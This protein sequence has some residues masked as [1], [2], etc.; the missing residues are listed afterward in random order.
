MEGIMVSMTSAV[1]HGSSMVKFNKQQNQLI[2]D[3]Q[4]KLINDI[5]DFIQ[6]QAQTTVKTSNA[7]KNLSSLS[8][9]K[10]VQTTNNRMYFG[11]FDC[12]KRKVINQKRSFYPINIQ[13]KEDLKINNSV[14]ENFADKNA[15]GQS[16]DTRNIAQEEILMLTHPE[17]LKAMSF[18]QQMNGILLQYFQFICLHFHRQIRIQKQESNSIK[19]NLRMYHFQFFSC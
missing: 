5:N 8:N 10:V 14:L 7:Q 12:R 11:K 9:A 19:I 1:Y 16:L 3:N 2:K 4:A 17:A 18:M 13:N 6:S 15:D